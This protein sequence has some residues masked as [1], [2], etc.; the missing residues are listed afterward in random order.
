MAADGA[1]F[2]R[3]LLD[4]TSGDQGLTLV[5]DRS[6]FQACPLIALVFAFEMQ[7]TP[8]GAL[9]SQLPTLLV[10]VA[11]E[12]DLTVALHEPLGE[13]LHDVAPAVAQ[14]QEPPLKPP[15]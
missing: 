12:I 5:P 4:Q 7:D 9:V 6:S 2:V 11:A 8:S 15:S 14:P 10:P 3:L 1:V 13:D